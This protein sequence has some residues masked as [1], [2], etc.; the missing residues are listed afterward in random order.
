MLFLVPHI[1]RLGFSIG[2]V[3]WPHFDWEQR[4]CR[5]NEDQEMFS[6]VEGGLG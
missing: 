1:L 3:F 6:E 5:T 2:E 4:R